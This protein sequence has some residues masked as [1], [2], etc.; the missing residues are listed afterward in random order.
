M[1]V[2][3]EVMGTGYTIYTNGFS[4]FLQAKMMQEFLIT[5]KNCELSN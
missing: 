3:N 5:N 1:G 4:I 2:V